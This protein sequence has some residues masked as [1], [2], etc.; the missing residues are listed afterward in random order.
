MKMG[1]AGLRREEKIQRNRHLIEKGLQ[2]SVGR[3]AT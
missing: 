3:E 2:A 1:K